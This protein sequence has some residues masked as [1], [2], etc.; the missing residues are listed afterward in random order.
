ME[1]ARE[2]VSVNDDSVALLKNLSESFGPSGFERE[3]ASIV[4]EAGE[5]YS[6]EVLFDKLGSVISR[7]RGKSDSPRILLAG[8]WTR[9]A[10]S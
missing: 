6:D 10:L 3:T 7:K 5:K 2:R 4:K 1:R 8:T 9:S